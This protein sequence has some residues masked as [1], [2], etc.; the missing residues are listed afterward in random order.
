[1]K[2]NRV[3]NKLE[4]FF[5]QYIRPVHKVTSIKPNNDGWDAIVEVI[6]EKDYMEAYAEDEIIGVYEVE[7][8]TDLEVTSFTRI[9]MRPRSD[10]SEE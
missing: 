8:D 1:M 2:I 5:K 4:E 3:L 6:E 9:R 10:V 7:M